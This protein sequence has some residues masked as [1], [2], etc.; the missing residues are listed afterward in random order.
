MYENLNKDTL[1]AIIHGLCAEYGSLRIC[2]L[3]MDGDGPALVLLSPVFCIPGDVLMTPYNLLVPWLYD[4][5]RQNFGTLAAARDFFAGKTSLHF[6]DCKPG[7][8]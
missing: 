4:A 2:G 1:S 5:L 7:V 3:D 8:K 6:E